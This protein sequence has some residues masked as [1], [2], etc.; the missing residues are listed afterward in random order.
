MRTNLFH[1]D[2][3]F[4][5][6]EKDELEDECKEEKQ[7]P[8][9][10]LLKVSGKSASTVENK[11]LK[12]LLEQPKR[13]SLQNNLK[14]QG[15]PLLKVNPISLAPV[16]GKQ[17]KN[18]EKIKVVDV[19]TVN[20]TLIE[21]KD[22]PLDLDRN[23]DLTDS[24][25]LINDEDTLPAPESAAY[26]NI[27]GIINSLPE[28]YNTQYVDVPD[29]VQIN[30]FSLSDFEQLRQIQQPETPKQQ[31][32]QFIPLQ[33]S[34]FA[35][36]AGTLLQSNQNQVFQTMVNGKTTLM[37]PGNSYAVANFGK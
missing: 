33:A 13:V 11:T 34:T 5:L 18:S 26:D 37:S 8:E 14:E 3:V 35:V 15:T 7:A 20:E 1:I 19:N 21:I 25:V 17:G 29:F 28:T 30:N 23:E 4:S 32:N 24:T 16:L 27:Q 6:F 2:N 9:R 31:V 12:K 36:S 10:S 22:E